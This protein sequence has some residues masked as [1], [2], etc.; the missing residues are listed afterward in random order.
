MCWGYIASLSG[1]SPW[2]L[3]TSECR[4]SGNGVRAEI[5]EEKLVVLPGGLNNSICVYD[6]GTGVSSL[7][8]MPTHLLPTNY[9]VSATNGTTFFAVVRNVSSGTAV[10]LEF[11]PS[12]LAINSFVVPG[13]TAVGLTY[14]DGYL[15][16]ILEGGSLYRIDPQTGSYTLIQTL[17]LP[18]SLGFGDRLEYFSGALLLVRDSGTAEAWVIPT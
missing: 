12:T 14:G 16:L 15:W 10:L 18:A 5:I 7:W 8:G 6:L 3:L 9:S 4:A 17:F 11:T 1:T 2:A 13:Y